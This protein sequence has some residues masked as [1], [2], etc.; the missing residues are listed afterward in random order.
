MD[1]QQFKTLAASRYG[2]PLRKYIIRLIADLVDVR[3]LKEITQE[4]VKGKR[5]AADILEEK[6]LDRLAEF[7]SDPS[8]P[9]EFE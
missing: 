5:F 2:Q 6:L 3:N 1:S 4:E 9:T 7:Q 8:Q